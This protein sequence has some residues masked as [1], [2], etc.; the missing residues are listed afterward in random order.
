M[1]VFLLLLTAFLLSVKGKGSKGKCGPCLP[2]GCEPEKVLWCHKD[3]EG[4]ETE[5]CEKQSF[6][7]HGS[8]HH[9]DQ[10]WHP[11]CCESCPDCS[12]V[13]SFLLQTYVSRLYVAQQKTNP[14]ADRCYRD[15]CEPQFGGEGVTEVPHMLDDGTPSTIST[16]EKCT[17]ACCIYDC[18]ERKGFFENWEEEDGY[19]PKIKVI[20][21]SQAYVWAIALGNCAPDC[22]EMINLTKDALINDV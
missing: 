2:D 7:G 16:K 6:D 18:G 10:S 11:G 1:K 12:Y 17:L 9:D 5:T 20:S 13:A 4:E 15:I 3:K 8:H 14:R 22:L 19:I 21:I